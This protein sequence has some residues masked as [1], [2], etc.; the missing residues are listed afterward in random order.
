MNAPLNFEAELN[1]CVEILLLEVGPPLDID[2][3][4]KLL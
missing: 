3:Q 2:E 1:S 4:Q